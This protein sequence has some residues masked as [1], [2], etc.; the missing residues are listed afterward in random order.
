MAAHEYSDLGLGDTAGSDAD[1]ELDQFV[2]RRFE[3]CAVQAE[4]GQHRDE[5]RTLVAVNKWMVLH[6]VEEVCGRLL[7]DARMQK[8]TAERCGGHRQ[9]GLQEA[10]VS[11]RGRAAI[12]CDLVGVKREYFVQ[13]QKC[14]AH[15]S[16]SRRKTP[17]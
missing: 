7:I 9:R 3:S 14:D 15:Y 6:E 1:H 4:K 2:V 11:N 17:P 12:M 16:A 8:L 13:R 10:D 5:P